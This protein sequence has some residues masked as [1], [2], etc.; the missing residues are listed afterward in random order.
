M[1]RGEKT[2]EKNELNES[3]QVADGISGKEPK[4]EQQ[5]SGKDQKNPPAL[6]AVGAVKGP[7]PSH[8]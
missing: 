7:F 4:D 6:S 3:Q 2:E 5:Y 8:S 1:L